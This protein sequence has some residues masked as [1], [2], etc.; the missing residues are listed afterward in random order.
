VFFFQWGNDSTEF[1]E[2]GGLN[3]RADMGKVC[4]SCSYRGPMRTTYL[5]RCL[6]DCIRKQPISSD[7]PNKGIKHATHVIQLGPIDLQLVGQSVQILPRHPVDGHVD[8]L[9]GHGRATTSVRTETRGKEGM[10]FTRF[11]DGLGDGGLELARLASC[12]LS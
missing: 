5:H 1:D 10:G 9:D 11:R 6:Q 3:P 4:Q 12:D 7:P 8:E 2:Q